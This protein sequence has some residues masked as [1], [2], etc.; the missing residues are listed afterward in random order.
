MTN[1][2]LKFLYGF[3]SFHNGFVHFDSSHFNF[4][5]QSKSLSEY[6]YKIIVN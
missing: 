1:H 2:N 5:K 6:F 4:R 3:I